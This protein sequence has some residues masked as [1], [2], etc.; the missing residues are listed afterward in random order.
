MSSNALASRAASWNT[1]VA[2]LN[3]YTAVTVNASVYDVLKTLTS[4]T[5]GTPPTPVTDAA[6][7]NVTVSARRRRADGDNQKRAARRTNR[8]R[9]DLTFVSFRGED[10]PPQREKRPALTALKAPC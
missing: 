6:T 1:C 8:I 9:L 7:G 3:R 5:N 4:D 10:M 2:P